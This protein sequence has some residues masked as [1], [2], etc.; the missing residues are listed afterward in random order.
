MQ[1][2]A[3]AIGAVSG[4]HTQPP[5]RYQ[6]LWRTGTGRFSP[7]RCFYLSSAL[8]Q[9]PRLHAG[10]DRGDELTLRRA[11]R[12]SWKRHQNLVATQH[13][14]YYH[15]DHYALYL[16]YQAQ[17]HSGGAWTATAASN[18]A[19]FCLPSNVNSRLVEFRENGQLRM[20]S[21]IDE[22]PD[23]ISSVYTFFDPDVPGASLAPTTFMAGATVPGT[24]AT[25]SLS[26]YWIKDSRK[27][28]YK[29]GF[30]PL[31]GLVEGHG[32]R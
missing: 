26:W 17:R 31:Q 6:C 14:L 1:L 23:G 27:M 22:L 19:I 30:R 20:I 13:D 12:R 25:L 4:G 10:T 29:A 2:S 3:G 5:D 21:I 11:Q 7:Q 15:P 9:L 32:S 18:T 28:A 8:R 24:E 16:R